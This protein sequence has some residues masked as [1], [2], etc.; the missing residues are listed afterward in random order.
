MKQIQVALIDY[1][2]REREKYKSYLN[3]S[4]YLNCVL[5][6]K[7]LDLFFKYRN[8]SNTIDIVLYDIFNDNSEKK[9][10]LAK[11]NK[12]RKHLP[13]CE[14]IILSQKVEEAKVVSLFKC[15]IN[16]YIIK[17]VERIDLEKYLIE[18]KNGGAAFSPKI[19]QYLLKSV[20]RQN[21]WKYVKPSFSEKQEKIIFLL[22]EGN[23]NSEIA[24]HLGISINGVQYHIRKIY[25]KLK[26]KNRTELN[27]IYLI[28]F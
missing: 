21:K 5:A 14:L 15:G 13:F 19:A 10:Y 17:D 8:T 28:D 7:S 16:G 25:K 4:I 22:V 24:D 6:V 12:L 1:D 27:K 23:S 9:N 18:T 20:R 11:V 26:I 3:Q 2:E